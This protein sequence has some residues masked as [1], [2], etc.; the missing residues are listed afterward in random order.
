[1]DAF[2]WNIMIVFATFA[3][4]MY[5]SKT[6]ITNTIG[7]RKQT[8]EDLAAL[9]RRRIEQLELIQ[10]NSLPNGDPNAYAKAIVE[11]DKI[12]E[13]KAAPGQSE[14]AFKT[15]VSLTV[16]ISGIFSIPLITS[17]TMN[18]MTTRLLAAQTVINDKDFQ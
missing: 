12:A 16:A 15:I 17:A 14:D 5:L 2:P 9:E 13:E 11:L 1:M 8:P 7:R 3:G 18:M 10:K 6:L 4:L